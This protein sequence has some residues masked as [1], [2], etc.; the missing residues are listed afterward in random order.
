MTL[1][2]SIYQNLFWKG[3][4]YFSLFML[5]VAIAR[6]YT[7]TVSGWIFYISNY[8][9]LII[10]LASLSLES[11]MI[12][13][14]SKNEINPLKLAS[15]SL[16]WAFIIGLLT[17]VFILIFYNG[18]P[19]LS[20]KKSFLQTSVTYISGFILIIFF[21]ALFAAKKDF[22]TPNIIL[23]FTNIILGVLLPWK[24]GFA[25]N[26]IDVTTYIKIYF[27]SFFIEGFAIALFFLF[28]YNLSF[29]ILF[30]TLLE[31]KKLFRFS[32]IALSSNIIFFLLYR[33]DY[34]FVKYYCSANDMG[35]YIQASK[36]VQLIIIVPSTISIVIFPFIAANN[37]DYKNGLLLLSRV[38]MFYAVTVCF[39]IA[40]TGYWLF[41]LIFGSSFSKMYFPFLMLIPGVLSLTTLYPYTA[42]YSGIN[43]IKKNISGSIIGLAIVIILDIVLIPMLGIKGA[44]MASSIGYLSYQVYIMLQFKKLQKIN[45]LD[46]YLLKKR[47]LKEI[48]LLTK[49]K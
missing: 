31:Y 33:I 29:S 37:R 9:S 10:L 45:L 6:C 5:N 2:K 40:I 46:C 26:N 11:G 32:L 13:Y 19:N 36:L 42:Y 4:Y 3:L 39:M 27:F 43:Q 18:Q 17:F 12:F 49:I 44:A 8:Y 16:L 30:P 15:F 35:N 21:S 25:I 47:D 20:E 7:A 1:T 24:H 23:V 14:S 38:L 34:W 48:F 28:K 22:R 41:P